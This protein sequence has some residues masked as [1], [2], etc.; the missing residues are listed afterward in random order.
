MSDPTRYATRWFVEPARDRPWIMTADAVIAAIADRPGAHH[1][2]RVP[3]LLGFGF[4]IQDWDFQ[5]IYDLE[6]GALHIGTCDARAAAEVLTTWFL[7]LLP[8]D[9]RIVF[10]TE[11]GV[12]N[13]YGD[14]DF[15]IPRNAGLGPVHR[16]LTDHLAHVWAPHQPA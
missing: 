1:K 13:G 4:R 9:V 8:T 7:G 6:T 12:E 11:D 3:G 5:G 2:E 16:A 15:T 14:T 10:N